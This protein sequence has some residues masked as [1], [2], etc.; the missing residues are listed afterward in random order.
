MPIQSPSFQKSKTFINVI[1]EFN[2]LTAVMII[3]YI[4]INNPNMFSIF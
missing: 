3:K 1:I 2:V 4:L